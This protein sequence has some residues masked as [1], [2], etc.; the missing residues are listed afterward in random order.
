MNKKHQRFSKKIFRKCRGKIMMKYKGYFGDIKE[1][2]DEAGII[3]GEVVGLKDVITFQ[4]T[5]VQELKKAFHDSVDDYLVWCEERSEKPE[6]TYSGNFCLRI[7]PELHA[8]LAL[9]AVRRGI[10]LNELINGKLSK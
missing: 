1:F 8:H 7:K 4:G 5:T 9:E 10:S 6:K 2:D 3:H